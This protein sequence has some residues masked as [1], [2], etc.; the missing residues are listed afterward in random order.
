[1]SY[2]FASSLQRDPIAQA[3]VRLAIEL[4]FDNAA[5]PSGFDTWAKSVAQLL[6]E[7]R[8]SGDLAAGVDL[9]EAAGV[10][11]ASFTGLQLVSEALS[12]RED[13]HERIAQWWRLLLPGLA[14]TDALPLVDVRGS[15]S[16]DIPT[17]RTPRTE[18]TAGTAEK[19]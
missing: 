15:G 11:I 5:T 2:S 3:S 13:L 17:S 19:R 9:D 16:V 8:M 4:T 1:M 7:A 12:Q 6:G 18:H 14:S 10:I